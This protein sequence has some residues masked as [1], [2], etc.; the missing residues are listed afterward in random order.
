MKFKRH[1]KYE[2]Q[3]LDMTPLIDV[4]FQ[5]L[6]FFMLSSSFI[7]QPGI[8]IR[9]PEAVTSKVTYDKMDIITLATNHRIFFNDSE[10]SAEQLNYHLELIAQKDGLILIKADAK[11]DLGTVVYVWDLCRQAGITQLNIA[12]EPTEL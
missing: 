1:V 11:V 10:V 7:L 2:K 3:T 8:K 5:L 4:V 6:L 12:T 9:L